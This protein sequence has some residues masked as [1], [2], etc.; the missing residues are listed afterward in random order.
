MGRHTAEG[1]VEVRY[2]LPQQSINNTVAAM[3]KR[4]KMVLAEK[5]ARLSSREREN[6]A[7]KGGNPLRLS[8]TH[9]MRQPD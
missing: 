3:P 4:A 7:E 2:K 5:G 8:S 9:T 1:L 6:Y